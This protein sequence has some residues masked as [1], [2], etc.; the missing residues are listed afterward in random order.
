MAPALRG[1]ERRE[2]AGHDR[3]EIFDGQAAAFLR[4]A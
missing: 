3:P 2:A 1:A 4:R